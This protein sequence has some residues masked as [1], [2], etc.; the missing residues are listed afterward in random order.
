MSQPLVSVVM[1]VYNGERYLREAVDSVLKQTYPAVELLAVNDGS[2]DGSAALLASYAGRIVTIEQPN[3]GV[4]AARNAGITRARGEFIAF[5]DQDDWWRPE[6]LAAQVA[7]MQADGSLGLVHTDVAYYDDAQHDFCPSP[8]PPGKERFVGSCYRRLLLG[9]HVSNSSVL[10][11]AAALRQVGL[12]SPEIA[13]NSVQDYDL[14]L[15]IARH[16]AFGFVPQ[17]LTV[18][19]VHADQGTWNRRLMCGEEAR[20]LERIVADERLADDPEVRRRMAAL[21]DLL[22]TAHLDA[23]DRRCARENYAHSLAWHPTRRAR[24]I[25]WA[26]FLPLSIIRQ[27]QQ[28]RRRRPTSA[29]NPSLQA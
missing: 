7:L 18:L 16:F 3:Q 9:N 20:L 21:Y 28:A 24:L 25:W 14:W 19:R 26:T 27:L 8:D 23:G 12:C 17:P 29:E 15:R 22:A 1:P 2:T 4:G 13:G 5:L 6:K 10:V 11:R